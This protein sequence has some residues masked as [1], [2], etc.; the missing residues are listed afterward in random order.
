MSL[1][2]TSPSTPSLAPPL[3]FPPSSFPVCLPRNLEASLGKRCSLQI[4]GRAQNSWVLVISPLCNRDLSDTCWCLA[5][6]S[7]VPLHP[8]TFPSS[9]SGSPEMVGDSLL[10]SLFRIPGTLRLQVSLPGKACSLKPCPPGGAKPLALVSGSLI[11]RASVA[12]YQDE[13]R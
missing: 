2:L 4:Q 8:F 1:L 9:H 13:S 7:P 6:R 12:F 11:C 5:Q 10:P 3:P